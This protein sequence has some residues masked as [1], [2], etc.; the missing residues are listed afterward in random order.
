VTQIRR[1]LKRAYRRYVRECMGYNPGLID[2]RHAHYMGY[3]VPMSFRQ[4]A[5]YVNAPRKSAPELP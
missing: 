5:W 1:N 3:T 4:W 2:R